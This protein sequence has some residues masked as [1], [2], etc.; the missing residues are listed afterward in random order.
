[1]ESTVKKLPR[2]SDKKTLDESIK[3]DNATLIGEYLI[4]TRDTIINFKCKCSINHNKTYRDIT[5]R[6]GAFCETCTQTNNVNKGNKTKEDKL[7]S[8]EYLEKLQKIEN[9]NI[10]NNDE[11]IRIEKRNNIINKINIISIKDDEW[12]IHPEI[13][14]HEVNRNCIIRNKKTNKIVN[15]S[16]IESGRETITI[17]KIKHQKH[18]FMMECIYN[19]ILSDEY[20]IDHIDS[21]P[22]NN[23]LENLQILTRKEHAIKTKQNQ[24]IDDTYIN[25]L[26]KTLKYVK[27]DKEYFF[28]S[29]N[30]ASRILGI[31][32]RTIRNSLKLKKPDFNNR[33]WIQ[34]IDKNKIN[35]EEWKTLENFDGLLISNKGRIQYKNLANQHITCG[36]K[37]EQDYYTIGY[38]SKRYKVHQL[39]CMAFNGLPSDKTMTVDHID[40]D[41]LN[42]CAKNLRWATKQE[43]A[44]N[45]SKVKPVEVYNLDTFK[46]VKKYNSQSDIVNEYNINASTINSNLLLSRNENK[47]RYQLG[48]NNN[49]SVRYSN[50][51]LD[52]KKEREKIILNYDI[53]ILNRDKNKRKSNDE[54]LP[55][56]ITKY[57]LKYYLTIKFRNNQYKNSSKNLDDLISIKNKWL[58]NEIKK[59]MDKI[60]NIVDDESNENILVK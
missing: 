5:D 60:D 55:M 53:E 33:Q 26:S 58:E 2:K 56:H 13:I 6:G 8:D 36:S 49:I 9:Q 40:R 46:I 30:E 31:D 21:N 29:I 38:K 22:S 44:L 4:L 34:I 27:D 3:R 37:G 43:Q 23:K 7:S 11:K 52:E 16:K 35:D 59:Y 19:I 41:S 45:R 24:K 15:G 17:N 54:N 42:N 28:K 25:K 20:D 57:G 10:Y 18:R 12:F 48:S 1:M 50:M 14:T 51:T 47:I 32:R 39:V